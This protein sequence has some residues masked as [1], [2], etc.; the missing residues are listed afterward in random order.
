MSTKE[1][2]ELISLDTSNLITSLLVYRLA[3]AIIPPNVLN[4]TI[5]G[6]TDTIIEQ[7]SKHMDKNMVEKVARDT[8]QNMKDIITKMRPHQ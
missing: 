3:A 7:L 2:A 8:A 4:I 5:D 6:G 1:D